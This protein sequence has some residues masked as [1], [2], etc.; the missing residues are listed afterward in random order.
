MRSW[1]PGS[2]LGGKGTVP[3]EPASA[4]LQEPIYQTVFYNN[5]SLNIEAYLYKPDG[6]GPFPVVIYNHGSR[7]GH[8]RLEVPFVYVGEMLARNGYAVLVPERRGYGKSDGETWSQAVG[9]DTRTKFINRLK[10]ETTDVLAGITYLTGLQFVDTHRM[11]I[12]G[13]SL[14]GIISVFAA[15]E[16]NVF[17]AM[18]DQAGGALSWNL[19]PLLQQDLPEAAS[20]I[21]APS[22]CM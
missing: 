17:R 10:E 8:E 6:V 1:R 2:R 18:I 11:A 19:S 12:M 7:R 9:S 5:G 16:R 20:L 13:W 3:R 15:S 14:G 4:G 21:K 22:L